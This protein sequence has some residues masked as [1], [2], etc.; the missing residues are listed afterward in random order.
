LSR[1]GTRLTLN[2]IAQGYVADRVTNILRENGFDRILADL[3]RSELYA[4]GQRPDGQAWRI[5]LANPRNPE[6][7]AMSVDLTDSALCT[8]GGYG[9]KFEKTGKYH[10]LFDPR[11]GDSAN[12][13]IAVSVFA[14]SAMAA[15]GLSTA[16]YVTPPERG[17]DLL[18]NFR[19]ATAI[20]TLPDGS[21]QFL[22]G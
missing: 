2:G 18:A 4:S 11:T 6:T 10:H 16:L 1:P 21:P 17:R 9:T 8:S 14:P 7:L 3:G 19:S 20:A 15:D 12:H 22:S 5:G 13:Y